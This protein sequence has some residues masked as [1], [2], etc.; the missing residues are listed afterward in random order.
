MSDLPIRGDL[1][2][3][4]TMLT[5]AEICRANN[6]TAGTVLVSEPLDKST[7]KRA[8]RIVLT[9]IGN[10]VV[11]AYDL[12]DPEREE[13]AWTLRLRQWRKANVG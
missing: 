2:T 6:W 5:S 10:R 11:L 9:A 8:Q 12:D 13:Q 7:S 1:P 4:E 3:Q